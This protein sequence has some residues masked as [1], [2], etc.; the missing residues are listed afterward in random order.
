MH[1]IG[2]NIQESHFTTNHSLGYFCISTIARHQTI[3]RLA[4]S[5]INLTASFLRREKYWE[6]QG[7][8]LG[9]FALHATTMTT[10]AWFLH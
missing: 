3:F 5:Q 6:G 2:L 8:N 1:E 7:S 10:K 9:P 4:G